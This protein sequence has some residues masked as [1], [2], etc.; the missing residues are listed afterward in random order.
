MHTLC[1][2]FFAAELILSVNGHT[3][4]DILRIEIEGGDPEFNV[5]TLFIL[6]PVIQLEIQALHC[7]ECSDY[8]IN[9]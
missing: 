4:I 1:T 2:V 9:W 5:L 6:M 7:H 8:F 3:F